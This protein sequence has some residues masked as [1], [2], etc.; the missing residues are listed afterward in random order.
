MGLGGDPAQLRAE[1]N[2]VRAWAT[3]VEDDADRVLAATDVD[4]VGLSAD[5]WRVRLDGRV[6][7]VRAVADSMRTAA[8]SIDALADALEERQQAIAAL[9]DQAGRTFDDV[10]GALAS[11]AGD[12]LDVAQ[13][14]ADDAWDTGKDVVSQ[15]TPW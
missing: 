5:A 15:V 7:D 11:G 10:R 3:D 14:W 12:A 2:R 1:A 8:Q 9:L 13:G 4:W 6:A